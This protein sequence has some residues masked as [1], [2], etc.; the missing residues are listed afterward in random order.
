MPRQGED[1]I[2]TV[3]NGLTL[4]RLCLIP[5]FVWVLFGLHD[6]GA[7]AVLLGF[8]GATDWVD[9]YVARRFD[10]VSNLGKILDPTADRLLLG[11]AGVSIL[12][13]GAVPLV[14]AVLVLA[15]EALVAGGTLVLAAMGARRIDVTIWGK[16]GTFALMVA[17]PLFLL[18]HDE[19]FGWHPAARLVAWVASIVGIVLG[20]YAAA[21]YV[22]LAKEALGKR[23]VRGGTAHG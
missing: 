23:A 12:V 3:P 7:A 19:A 15:R 1:R 6:R 2:W 11:V 4:V 20:W 18:G 8:L 22:P 9:G 14:I 21:R 16:A 17:L 13:D 5:L 10:Q